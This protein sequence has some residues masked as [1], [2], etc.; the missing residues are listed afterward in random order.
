MALKR[1][2]FEYN[3]YL[4]DINNFYSIEI[5]EN[6]FYIWNITLFGPIDTIFDGGIFKCEIKF[7]ETYPNTPPQFKFLTQFPH[8]NIYQDGRICIS[9]LHEGYDEFNYENINERWNP[10]HSVNSI[11]MSIISLLS[12]PNLESPA[13]VEASL[14]WKKS[15]NEYK[16]AIYHIIAK[17]Q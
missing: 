16:K 6:N 5:N 8:P 17:T 9:I 10:S 11:I 1:L 7:P 13:N 2:R 14:L 4:K 12:S 15:F 3:Q